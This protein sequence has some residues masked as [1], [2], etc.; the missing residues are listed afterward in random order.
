M[1]V[2]HPRFGVGTVL[3]VEQL[4]D[5]VKVTVRFETVGSKRLLASYA[6][7]EPA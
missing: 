2:R 6:K 3:S 7:L 5:D 1:K 4:D